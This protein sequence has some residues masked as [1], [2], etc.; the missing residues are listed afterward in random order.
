MIETTVHCETREVARM[1][2]AYLDA[3]GFPA[4]LAGCYVAVTAPRREVFNA[5]PRGFRRGV[6]FQERL[7]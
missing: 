7:I 1:I 5:L 6:I 3:A 2:W 4:Q